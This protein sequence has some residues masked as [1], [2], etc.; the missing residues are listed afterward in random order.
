MLEHSSPHEFQKLVDLEESMD[1]FWRSKP[2]GPPKIGDTDEET[3]Y[4]EQSSFDLKVV[5]DS[6]KPEGKTF[7]W[8]RA[9]SID[10]GFATAY[11]IRNRMNLEGR[12][13][14]IPK[15]GKSTEAGTEIYGPVEGSARRT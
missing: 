15:D 3:E 12:G 9:E 5:G 11:S 6:S 7:T 2:P 1:P 10:N 8:F 13:G 4:S 14:A